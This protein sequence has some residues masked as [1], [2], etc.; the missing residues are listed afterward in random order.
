MN[1]VNE[2]FDHRFV[3]NAF[4]SGF[5]PNLIN[6]SVVS[7]IRLSRP[8]SMQRPSANLPLLSELHSITTLLPLFQTEHGKFTS[9]MPLLELNI[10]D[11]KAA[12]QL[13]RDRMFVGCFRTNLKPG[14]E[15]VGPPKAPAHRHRGRARLSRLGS[16]AVENLGC[17]SFGLA[18][19][20]RV[21]IWPP[22]AVTHGPYGDS[23]RS[24]GMNSKPRDRRVRPTR[25]QG[26]LRSN[27]S[28]CLC[29]CTGSDAIRRRHP[30][31]LGCPL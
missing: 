3:S 14:V 12:S 6:R 2:R 24:Q 20:S 10:L 4:R 15:S 21:R 1:R 11:A 30:C 26:T 22:S 31:S 19:T 9:P 5:L 8:L 7:C 16:L 18:L 27:S 25:L 13:L 23:F 17:F 28:S 29:E